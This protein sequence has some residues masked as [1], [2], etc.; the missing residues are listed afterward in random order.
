MSAAADLSKALEAAQMAA[1][2]LV[3]EKARDEEYIR[4]LILKVNE[5]TLR[6]REE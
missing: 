3:S 6:L 1:A 4:D 5:L 2:R